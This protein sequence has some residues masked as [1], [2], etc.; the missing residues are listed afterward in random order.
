MTNSK[1]ITR[2]FLHSLG[3][4][5]Y[6]AGVAWIMNHANKLFGNKPDPGFL[7]PLG[8]LMLFVL[9]AAVVGFLVVG[10]PAML[11]VSGEKQQGIKLFAFTLGWLFIFTL[12]IL[13]SM[14]TVLK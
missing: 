3:A 5:I 1:I 8:I 10:K 2:S 14:T 4:L 11:Y 9:S 13:T 6:I 7:A 12:I